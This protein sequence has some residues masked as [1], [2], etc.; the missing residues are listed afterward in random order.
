MGTLIFGEAS[1]QTISGRLVSLKNSSTHYT[2][3]E[4]GIITY[5]NGTDPNL[6]KKYSLKKYAVLLFI[7]DKPSSPNKWIQ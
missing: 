6:G 2:T 1:N 7:P 5:I 4:G 3:C